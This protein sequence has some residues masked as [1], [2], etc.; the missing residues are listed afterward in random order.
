MPYF[1]N[2][3]YAVDMTISWFN[4]PL[5]GDLGVIEFNDLIFVP[6]RIYWITNFVPNVKRGYHAHRELR[7]YLFVIRGIT[8]VDLFRGNKNERHV[9]T[10]ATG[11]I[12]VESGTWRE[13][14]SPDDSTVL[15]VLCDRKYDSSDY[16]RDFEEYL[17]WF[18]SKN[19]S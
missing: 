4:D 8:F 11:P 3:R 15:G 10:N 6:R 19:E 7:Q 18:K 12:F 13:F 1:L 14:W 9:L 16:L 5:S 17:D 2:R